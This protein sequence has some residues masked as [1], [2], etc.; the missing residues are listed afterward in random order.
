MFENLRKAFREAVDNFNKELNRDE[1]P[2]VVDG[3]LRQMHEEVTDAKAQVFTLEEQIKRALQL[4]ELEEKEAATC[5]RREEMASKI[6]DEETAKVAAEYAEKHE[7]RKEIQERKALALRE[8]LEMKRAEVEDML[9]KL[10]EAKTKREALASTSGRVQARNSMTEADE[11]FAQMDRMADKI[12][13]GDHQ[14][15]AEEELMAE[16]GDMEPSPPRRR[17]PPTDEEAEAALKELK[18]RMGEG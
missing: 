10:K 14:R 1:I 4:A 6:G 11:L 12:E 16:F 13:G 8:E 9:E 2:D 5:R 15:A 7:S 17:G 3:L 18:R